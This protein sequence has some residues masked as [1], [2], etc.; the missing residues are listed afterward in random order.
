MSRIRGLGPARLAVDGTSYGIAM[1]GAARRSCCLLPRLAS[2]GW[3]PVLFVGED[4]SAPYLDLPGVT[5]VPV[6]VPRRPGPVRAMAVRRV[7][8]PLLRELRIDVLLTETPPPPPD[9]PFVLTVHDLRSY[10]A[11]RWV[12]LGRRWWIRRSLPP[13]LRAAAAVV[14][15]SAFSADRLA[16][17]FPGARAIVAA[18][19]CDHFPV[20]PA[21]PERDE[22]VL[23]VGPWDRRK[24]APTLL[25]VARLT[26]R[27]RWV[28][29][30]RPPGVLPAN[31]EA[32]TLDDVAL[33]LLLRSAAAVV[34]PSRYE[35]FDLP[36]AEAL[37]QGACVIAS[38][39]PVHREVGGEAA[40]YF[41]PGDARALAE[42]LAQ[43][44]ADPPPAETALAQA[45]R[46]SWRGCAEVMDEVLRGVLGRG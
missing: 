10:D 34:C 44:F 31:A 38:D 46:F 27:R 41:P 23:A 25:E 30:G 1:S 5:T 33:G 26:P 16:H 13:A 3:E 21:A 11:P 9:L 37:A 40:R 39:I 8:P 7:L 36:L 42:Q 45:A 15:P 2:R 35:G 43:V 18:N 17:H 19:G 12:G 24:D 4:R 20:P 32:L 6:K 22:F 28:F 29:A 14:T